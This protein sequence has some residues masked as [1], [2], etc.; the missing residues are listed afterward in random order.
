[1]RQ[2]EHLN[3]RIKELAEV[4]SNQVN[5][6]YVNPV[7]SKERG[8]IWEDG[9]I[10]WHEQFQSKF[11]QLIIAEGKREWVGLTDEERMALFETA[12]GL[13]AYAKAIERILKEKNT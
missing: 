13:F 12:D 3:E 8:K 6:V 2:G 7:R 11:A 10:S 5:E 4:A 9:H 1:M